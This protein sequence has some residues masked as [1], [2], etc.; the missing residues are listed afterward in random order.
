[1]S[2]RYDVAVIGAGPAGQKAAI[3]AVKAGRTAI[4]VERA[5]QVGGDCVHRGTIPSK[6]LRETALKLLRVQQTAADV[7]LRPDTPLRDLVGR[8][9]DVVADQVR[10]QVDQLRRNGVEVRLG[11]ARFADPHRL[12]VQPVRGPETEITADIVVIATGS[13]PRQPDECGIDHADVL[14]SDSI[15]SLPYVPRSL[16]VLGGGVIG[17]EYASTFAA[18]GAQVTLVDRAPRPLGFMDPELTDSLLQSWTGRGLLHLPGRTATHIERGKGSAVCHLSDG[19]AVGA[20][21]VLV[22]LGRVAN[23]ADLDLERARVRC[24]KRGQVQVDDRYE[25]SAEGVFAV[26]DVIGFPALA[27]TSMEQGRRAMLHALGQPV[28]AEWPPLPVGIYT[29]PSLAS[30]GATEE[31]ALRTHGAIRVGRCFFDEV[32]RGHI[33]QERTGFLKLVADADGGR[34]LGVHAIGGEAPD[35][36]TVGQVAMLGGLGLSDFVDTVFN[37]PTW[38]QAYRVAGL[39]ALR[40]DA[41]AEGASAA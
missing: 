21:K 30:V 32:A 16:V 11:R 37:F 15:L 29:L 2:E 20:D 17:S 38:S 34:I 7:R 31:A 28:P 35:L 39:A 12:L 36:V 22:A 19:S 24:T 41:L 6:A 14:D 18:L 4:V 1:M 26:G 27:A 23:V 9:G 3:C 13:V 5:R 25:T 33:T 8:V 40:D 10:T